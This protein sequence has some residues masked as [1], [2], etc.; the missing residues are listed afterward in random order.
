[1]NRIYELVRQI[2]EEE[3]ICEKYKETIIVP[4][5]EKGDRGRCENYKG[6]ALGNAGYKILATIILEK[7][8]PYVEKITGDYQNG[9]RNRRCVNDNIFVLKIINE[10]ILEYNQS[11]QYLFIDFQQAYDSIHRDT[12]RKCM[13]NLK[14]LK[15]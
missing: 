3:R 15:N 7:I 9:F 13:K 10:K 8:K 5:Y 4:I 6:I 1:M 11:E 2:W 12:L 14:F